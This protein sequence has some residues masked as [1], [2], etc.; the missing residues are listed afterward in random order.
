MKDTLTF[1]ITIEDD[2]GNTL[3]IE[4]PGTRLLIDAKS[5]ILE[6]GLQTLIALPIL[7]V[8]KVELPK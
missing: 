4:G 2:A 1:S 3:L 8:R 5:L 6:S 7:Y